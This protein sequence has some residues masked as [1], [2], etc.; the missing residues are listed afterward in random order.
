M[1]FLTSWN[2]KNEYK[3]EHVIH[4]ERF[5]SLKL[6]KLKSLISDRLNAGGR[7]LYISQTSRKK[8]ALLGKVDR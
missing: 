2:E 6:F 4:A 1:Q 3:I 8:H 7:P 5:N